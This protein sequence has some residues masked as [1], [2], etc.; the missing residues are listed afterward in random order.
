MAGRVVVTGAGVISP[1]GAGLQTFEQALYHGDAGVRTSAR[2]DGRPVAEIPDFDPAPWLGNKGVRVLDRGARLLC[3]AAQMAL[4]DIEGPEIGLVCGTM[5]G[6]MHSIVEFDWTGVTEGPS[7]VNPMQFP[8]TVINSA[9]GQAAIRYKLRGLNSTVCAGTASGLFAIHYAAECL[10]LGRAQMLL[11]GGAEELCD[12]SLLG[13]RE[14]GAESPTGEPRPF[15]A[16]RDG[17]V[18]GEGAALWVVE[19]EESAHAR[20]AI[21]WFEICGFGARQSARGI[22]DFTGGVE[23]ASEA[24]GE[25]LLMSQISQSQIGCVVASASGSRLGD[26]ME[27][28]ALRN[29][30]GDAIERM[31]V[32]A[33]KG[34]L[35]E[36]L[37][38]GGAFA[39][40]TAGLALSRRQ[41]APTAGSGT[42]DYG[43]R[44]SREP[45]PVDGEYALVNAFSCDGNSAA[46]VI[47]Q[48]KN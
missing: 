32:C 35:G 40:M 29:V 16:E 22:Q 30:F 34:A 48:W 1:I 27:A 10:R 15:G 4:G 5:F 19:T 9:S 11:A 44:I 43:V 45:Q 6:S 25:A 21:P 47:R 42:A 41:L 31:P 2:F 17:A 26:A 14:T 3:V 20:N 28:R 46:L 23:D 12:E 36:S 24:M 37:G 7:Y 18:A 13:F 8:N 38:A 39:A 33:P